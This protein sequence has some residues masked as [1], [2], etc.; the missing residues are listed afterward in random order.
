[1]STIRVSNIQ[2]RTG[3]NTSTPA[4]I[5]NGIAK[6]WVNFNGTGTIDIRSSYNVTSIT[7]NGVGDYT[8]VLTNAL[9]DANY[10]A[11]ITCTSRGG[12]ANN[13]GAVGYGSATTV[14]SNST[15]SAT[16]LRIFVGTSSAAA[17]DAPTI[18]A[19]FFR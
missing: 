18:S 10:S 19:A 12:G 16:Q 14:T 11:V 15:Y 8:I 7:D 13:C 6:A 17:F 3:G 5:A 4:E 2:D 1:M 9:T